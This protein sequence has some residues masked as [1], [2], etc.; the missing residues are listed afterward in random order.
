MDAK[1]NQKA[2]EAAKAAGDDAPP[3]IASVV[4]YAREPV[5]SVKGSFAAIVADAGLPP[6]ITPHWLRHTAATWLM[7][8]GVPPF[9]A[10]GYLG[11]S[12]EVLE[13]HYAHHR[14]DYQAAVSA[15][16]RRHIPNTSRLR[17]ESA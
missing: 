12:M 10:K 17:S 11:M 2:V 16:P 5:D 3:P 14:P 4:H 6:E 15:S 9:E 13:E 1:A 8:A 7:E